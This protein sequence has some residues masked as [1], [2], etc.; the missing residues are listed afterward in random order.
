VERTVAETS[1]RLVAYVQAMYPT[2][3]E[4]LPD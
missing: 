4:Y 3:A 2:L 1:D